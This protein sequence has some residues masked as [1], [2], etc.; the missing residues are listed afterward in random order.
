[1]PFQRTM[2]G[3]IARECVEQY[4]DAAMLFNI[5]LSKENDS[6]NQNLSN[7]TIVYNGLVWM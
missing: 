1:M 3:G 5:K 4:N 2:A 7:S 6:L